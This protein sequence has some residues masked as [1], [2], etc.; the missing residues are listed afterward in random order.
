MTTMTRPRYQNLIDSLLVTLTLTQYYWI[1]STFISAIRVIN[2][3]EEIFDNYGE[4]YQM[5]PL[6]SRQN[7]LERQYFFE[8]ACKACKE[9]WPQIAS[10]KVL[11]TQYLC[12]S[13]NFAIA[14]VKVKKC[15]KCKNEVKLQKVARAIQNLASESRQ[16][17]LSLDPSHCSQVRERYMTIFKE[18]ERLV[19]PPSWP[20]VLCQQ[21]IS[22]CY[23]LE[24]NYVE[25]NA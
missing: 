6:S 8:C 11:E 12:R 16:V 7:R 23:S 17:I 2:A 3:G 24:G 1:L 21:V 13:C 18:M 15:P 22:Q 9:N 4:F 14:S 25:E 20:M 10:L 19:K 5:S